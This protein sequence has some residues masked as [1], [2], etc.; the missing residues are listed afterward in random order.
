[1]GKKRLIHELINEYFILC[2]FLFMTVFTDGLFRFSEMVT[3]L[4]SRDAIASKSPGIWN[5]GLGMSLIMFYLNLT[6]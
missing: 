2:P 5:N 1:M 4:V 3:Y 6:L